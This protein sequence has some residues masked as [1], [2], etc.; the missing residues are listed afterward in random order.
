MLQVHLLKDTVLADC[1]EITRAKRTLGF[2]SLVLE[3]K[4]AYAWLPVGL[5]RQLINTDW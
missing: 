1:G 5:L 4:D 2:F 3:I